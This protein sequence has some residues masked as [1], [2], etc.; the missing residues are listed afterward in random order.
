MLAQ[1]SLLL[2]AG[3]E[4]SLNASLSTFSG[5]FSL[6]IPVHFIRFV[7]QAMSRSLSAMISGHV[8][9]TCNPCVFISLSV[10]CR[11]RAEPERQPVHLQ[12]PPAAHRRAAG[13]ERQPLTG[14]VGR[15]WHRCDLLQLVGLSCAS[16]RLAKMRF[17][18][19][20]QQR[21]VLG[22]SRYF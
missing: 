10:H 7:L 1:L 3:D 13:R 17:F 14:A 15:S 4:Q 19:H 16:L 22:Y 21:Q 18:M 20:S 2:S 12:R 9:P 11:R 5:H 8:P 6:A